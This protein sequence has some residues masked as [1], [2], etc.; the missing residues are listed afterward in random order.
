MEVVLES[1]VG[2]VQIAGAFLG[3]PSRAVRARFGAT[4]AEAERT[5]PGDELVPSPSWSYT[6]AIDV[7]ATPERVWPWLVQ[8]GQSRAGFYSYRGLE[9]IAGCR[10]HNTTE[11]REEFQHLAIG[12]EVKLHPRAPGLEVKAVEPGRSL[13]LFGG[14]AGSADASVWA[15]HLVDTGDGRSRLIERGRYAHG[16]RFG[17]R[18]AFGPTLLEPVSFVMSRKM[19]SSIAEL[20]TIVP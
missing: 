3:R 2:A 10:I 6:H 8:I 13:V 7:A 5:F 20:A 4:P 14:T 11:I 9:N 19:L 15:F 18:L 1:I 12:D 17:S 16:D